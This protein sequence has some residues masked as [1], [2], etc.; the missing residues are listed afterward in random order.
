MN[1]WNKKK[2]KLVW[3][4]GW[5]FKCFFFLLLLKDK[6]FADERRREAWVHEVT[7]LISV[8]PHWHACIRL[9]FYFP[10]W[11]LFFWA[12]MPG[13]S[14]FCSFFL[15]VYSTVNAT[16][17]IT[18]LFCYERNATLALRRAMF[19]HFPWQKKKS[20]KKM[21]MLFWWMKTGKYLVCFLCGSLGTEE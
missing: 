14:F 20:S 3:A 18:N 2:K 4:L 10:F 13:D 12:I 6:S 1:D 11:F 7:R 8:V 15:H 9:F 21:T 17:L 16:F 19:T 5:F